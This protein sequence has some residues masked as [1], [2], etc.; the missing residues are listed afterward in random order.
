MNRHLALP[1]IVLKCPEP[2]VALIRLSLSLAIFFCMVDVHGI[3]EQ[4]VLTRMSL[5]DGGPSESRDDLHC[6]VK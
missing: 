5:S 6:V 1:G 2:M 3:L 4:K